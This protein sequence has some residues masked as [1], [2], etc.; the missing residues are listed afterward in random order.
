[1][2]CPSATEIWSVAKV[3][4]FRPIRSG[5][6]DCV[7]DHHGPRGHSDRRFRE[8]PCRLHFSTLSP[9]LLARVHVL[10]HSSCHARHP[11][12]WNPSLSGQ[13]PEW[14]SV[15]RLEIIDHRSSRSA[16]ACVD[17]SQCGLSRQRRTSVDCSPMRARLKK[18]P[19]ELAAS[20]V[21][22]SGE[23]SRVKL[24]S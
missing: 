10:A 11:Q 20:V 24:K 1:P 2:L 19:S 4:Y 15:L 16:C 5:P 8:G 14:P 18:P 13:S 21:L 6:A 12:I 22:R 9:W 23:S 7:L 3:V 17:Q